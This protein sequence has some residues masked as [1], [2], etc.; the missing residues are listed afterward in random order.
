MQKWRVFN[1]QR[2]QHRFGFEEDVAA[3]LKS[4]LQ[5]GNEVYGGPF[6]SVKKRAKRRKINEFIKY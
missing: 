3:G 6:F 5:P 4:A 2:L 1:R